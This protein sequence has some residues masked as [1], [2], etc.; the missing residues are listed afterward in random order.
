[1]EN[2]SLND[3]S[4]NQQNLQIATSN[5]EDDISELPS[6]QHVS[7]DISEELKGTPLKRRYTGV[8]DLRAVSQNQ[9]IGEPS[10]G[11]RT[12]S[13]LKSESNLALI[14]EI[15]PESIDEA[16]SDQYWIEAMKEE[17]SQLE[18]SKV[19]TL[20]PLPKRQSTIRTK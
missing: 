10:Q 9:I 12:R 4:Q 1:M 13:S 18:K 19:W 17:L 14:S 8:R 2:M 3:N 6:H 20:V 7:N 15:Q 11:I 16:L 5:D